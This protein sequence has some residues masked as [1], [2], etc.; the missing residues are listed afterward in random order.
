M[1]PLGILDVRG[2]GRREA[3][4]DSDAY[5]SYKA[6]RSD[7]R[8]VVQPGVSAFVSRHGVLTLVSPRGTQYSYSP[9]VTAMWIALRQ[10]GGDLDAAAKRLAVE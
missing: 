4:Q 9:E 3:E 1:L 5:S 6:R 10:Y 7:V 8:V 2:Q